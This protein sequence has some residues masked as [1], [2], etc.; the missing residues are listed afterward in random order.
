MIKVLKLR[1]R[2]SYTCNTY[3][4]RMKVSFVDRLKFL[5]FGYSI[6]FELEV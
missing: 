2:V 1:N 5:I 4:F 6:D 3:V